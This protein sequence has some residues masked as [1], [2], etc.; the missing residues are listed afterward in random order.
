MSLKTRLFGPRPTEGGASPRIYIDLSDVI[1][2]VIWHATGA[3]IQ[4]VQLEIAIA[5]VNSHPNAVPFSLYGDIW[6][7]LRSAIEETKDDNERLYARLRAYFPYPG[8]RPSF[9]HPLRTLRLT[10]AR[11]DALIDRLT[12]R[13]PRLNVGDILFVGGQFWM[14]ETVIN[15]CQTAVAQGA[16]L[17]VLIHDL[18]PITNRQLNGHDFGEEYRKILRLPAHFIVT[19]SLGAD[20]LARVKKDLGAAAATVSVVPLAQEF[21]GARRNEKGLSP[22]ERLADLVGADFVLCVGTVEVRKNHLTLLSVWE[23]LK[24][25]LGERLPTLVVA[26]RRGWK[27]EAA[28][29]KLDTP[30]HGVLFVESP[31]EEALRWLYSACLFTIFPS[32]FEGWGL[33]VGESLW[34]GKACAASNTSSIP[35]VG[36]DLCVYFSPN[37]PGEIKNAVRRL[38]DQKV[39]RSYEAKIEAAKLRSWAEVADDIERIVAAKPTKNAARGF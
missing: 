17:I 29:R 26:G 7:D 1:G 30:P 16:D 20:E 21:P 23:E 37:D 3:G 12:L 4:R 34:F 38:L 5:L 24:A 9:L 28:L 31:S 14:S 6:R 2:H 36:S 27:A 10:K 39:R 35:T 18:I 11:F 8:V 13:P 22:P 25:E 32:F 15:L 19:T 33:P